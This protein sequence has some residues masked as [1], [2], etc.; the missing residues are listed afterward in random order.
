MMK[1]CK[2]RCKIKTAILGLV[3]LL[4]LG[5]EKKLYFENRTRC[6]ELECARTKA[7]KLKLYLELELAKD[8]EPGKE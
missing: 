1:S 7:L 8:K 5:G 2:I 4:F 3:R 6:K